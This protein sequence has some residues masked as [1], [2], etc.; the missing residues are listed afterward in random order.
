MFIG[1]YNHTMD[2][3]GRFIIPS[4]FRDELD[5]EFVVTKG[6]DGCLFAYGKEEWAELAAKLRA[7][8]VSNKNARAFAR[9]MLAGAAQVEIDKQGRALV[10]QALREFVKIEKEVVLIGVGNRFELWNKDNWNEANLCAEDGELLAE[11]MED[12]GI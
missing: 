8:P 6:L 12:L 7:L 5:G 9:Y 11:K 1:E 3:K 4:K 2:E 10:P